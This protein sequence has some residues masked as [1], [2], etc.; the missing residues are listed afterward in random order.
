[1]KPE[2]DID[3]LRTEHESDEQ[4]AVRRSFMEEHKDKF[5]EA[6]LVTLAQ[7]F[8]NIEFLGC[9][10][11]MGIMED[12]HILGKKTIEDR[13]RT[14]EDLRNSHWSKEYPYL[15]PSAELTW[16]TLDV[17]C[18]K[19]KT[20]KSCGVTKVQKAEKSENIDN[21]DQVGHFKTSD[22]KS[23]NFAQVVN[24]CRNNA[25]TNKFINSRNGTGSEN[26]R[27]KVIKASKK[28]K[29]DR[30]KHLVETRPKSFFDFTNFNVKRINRSI[31]EKNKPS[32]TEDGFVNMF[33][34][35][36][37]TKYPARKLHS[38]L[39]DYSHFV[40]CKENGEKIV[41]N[42]MPAIMDKIH[43]RLDDLDIPKGD[44]TYI[45]MV[46]EF[47]GVYFSIRSADITEKLLEEVFTGNG[48]TFVF[49]QYRKVMSALL[50]PDEQKY[51]SVNVLKWLKYQNDYMGIKFTSWKILNEYTFDGFRRVSII[52][53]MKDAIALH[54]YN[55]KLNYL[56]TKI[57]VIIYPKSKRKLEADQMKKAMDKIDEGTNN[58]VLES[59]RDGNSDDDIVRKENKSDEACCSNYKSK[60]KDE[61]VNDTTQDT[62]SD[63]VHVEDEFD[64]ESNE[65]VILSL[66]DET[67]FRP[68]P[69]FFIKKE[70]SEEDLDFGEW[71]YVFMDNFFREKLILSMP[72]AD[73][74]KLKRRE[75][76][77][78]Y[79]GVK[80]KSKFPDL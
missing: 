23:K 34:D 57:K 64:F 11:M 8:T 9:R 69:L 72:K 40:V 46:D 39:T 19:H 55:Y 44:F 77:L 33:K 48:S 78:T 35:K 17:Y 29:D 75:A 61:E 74:L 70:N 27:V 26:K 59:K 14:C 12:M 20:S 3:S 65:R 80:V 51:N 38:Y 31:Y 68:Y 6:E 15:V 21:S 41:D 4:W 37:Q 63:N 50:I 36:K 25:N 30:N 54:K 24:N 60:T 5:S 18:L 79:Y 73:A 28:P 42:D 49:K 13:Q 52:I 76:T 67:K 43:E 66:A 2:L 47:T 32:D 53:P 56:D 62:S 1:M 7:L 71:K 58:L 16:I 22:E 10:Y 45:G